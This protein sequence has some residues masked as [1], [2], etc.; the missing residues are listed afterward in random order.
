M[1][2]LMVALMVLNLQAPAMATEGKI[3]RFCGYF[4]TKA[5]NHPKIW[6]AAKGIGKGLLFAVQLTGAVGN[7]IRY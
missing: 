7:T 1:K 5:D 4:Q 6:K 3:D 2:Y